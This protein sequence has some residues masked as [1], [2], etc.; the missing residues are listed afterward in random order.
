MREPAT[1]SGAYKVFQPILV[2]IQNWEQGQCVPENGGGLKKPMD[3]DG[4]ILRPLLGERI[5]KPNILN[6]LGLVAWGL[7]SQQT[8]TCYLP[9]WK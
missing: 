3:M 9:E 8:E 5:N 1:F 7:T 4:R 6:S 2:R